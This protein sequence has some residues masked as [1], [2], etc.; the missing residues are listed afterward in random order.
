ML[1]VESYITVDKK[2]LQEAISYGNYLSVQGE[3]LLF[4][5]G[6]YQLSDVY[7]FLKSVIH[8]VG[9]IAVKNKDKIGRAHV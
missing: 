2:I 1:P 4:I 8:V 3:N 9:K 7:T 5:Q 6:H